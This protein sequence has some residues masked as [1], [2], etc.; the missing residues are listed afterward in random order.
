MRR[1]SF[2]SRRAGWWSALLLG[3]TPRLASAF[4]QTHTCEFDG[5]EVCA[6]DPVTGCSSGGAVAHWKSGC[7][8]YAVQ[9]QGSR[10]QGITASELQS[11]VQTGFGIW[12]SV[13]CT[14]GGQTPALTATFRGQASC[15]QVEYNC[16]AGDGNA[17]IVMFR[18]QQSDLP[19]TTIALSTVMANLKTGEI[20]D[21]DIELNSDRFDFYL[22]ESEARPNAHD[23]RLVIN[24]ELGHM[25]GLSH[26]LATGALMRAAYD[27]VDRFPTED[28]INGM[29]QA[30]PVADEDPSCSVPPVTDGGAC[31]GLD[32]SCPIT[33]H[34]TT[35][36]QADTGCNLSAS[37]GGSPFGLGWAVA[38]GLGL[39]FIGRGRRLRR[40]RRPSALCSVCCSDR[41]PDGC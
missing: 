39:C 2:G 1:F 13:P 8:S 18:D 31:V 33:I 15:A 23:L 24:H 17:N 37:G 11:I 12:S 38:S 27:G 19:P 32:S 14:A 7:V 30:I 3:L 28:D 34:Q 10:A 20:L 35:T 16:G 25:L 9:D 4:C 6:L 36:S 21:V 5:T 41:S 22:D 29:C 40:A 26:T